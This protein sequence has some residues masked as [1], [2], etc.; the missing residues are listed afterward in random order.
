MTIINLSDWKRKGK[1]ESIQ[2][3]IDNPQEDNDEVMCSFTLEESEDEF[4]FTLETE[5]YPLPVAQRTLFGWSVQIWDF[6]QQQWVH[7]P[8]YFTTETEALDLGEAIM[9]ESDNA[10]FFE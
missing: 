10:A 5:P 8:D 6:H 9:R 4:E 1:R 3:Q 2:A 7:L